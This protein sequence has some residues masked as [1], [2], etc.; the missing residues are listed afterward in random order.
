MGDAQVTIT[1]AF[2]AAQLA[3]TLV[4]DSAG[5]GPGKALSAK[6]TA[7]QAAVNAGQTAI[8]CAGIT[9]YLGLVN[10]QTAKK[11]DPAEATLLATD[12]ANLADALGC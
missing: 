5:Q 4:S 11:L 12:A 8:A 2:T 7:I 3:E 1:Y 6:A 10:A 9:D